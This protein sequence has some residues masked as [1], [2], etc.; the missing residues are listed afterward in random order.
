MYFI[1][2]T[3]GAAD[4]LHEAPEA[5]GA[6]R[7]ARC[8]ARC[9]VGA[10]AGRGV[11]LRD[12]PVRSRRTMDLDG[13]IGVKLWIFMEIYGDLW[14]FMEICGDLWRFMEIYGY[15]WIIDHLHLHN[16]DSL[17]RFRNGGFKPLG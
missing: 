3:P 1:V 17:H 14:R 4:V 9:P 6:A 8:G 10:A 5:E 16:K 12:L 13:I 7:R 2:F 15:L 11:E